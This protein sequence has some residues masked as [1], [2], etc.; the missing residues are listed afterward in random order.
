MTDDHPNRESNRPPRDDIQ[1]E[2]VEDPPSEGETVEDRLDAEETIQRVVAA[3]DA[4]VAR[5]DTELFFSG[6]AAGFAITLTFLLH[7]VGAAA[8]SGPAATVLGS[9][10]YPLGFLYII[11]GRYQLYTENTLPPVTLVLERIA[12]VPT[13]LRVWGVVLVANVVG[14]A[15]GAFVLANSG[16]MSTDVAAAALTF[17]R[18]GLE[19]AAIDLFLKALFAGWLV[20]GLVWMLHSVRDSVSR[21]LLVYVVF[22]AIPAAELYHVVVSTVDALYL[23]FV[24]DAGLVAVTLG[25][26]LPVLVGNTVGGVV[27]VALVNY[28]QTSERLPGKDEAQPRL[29]L[30]EWAFGSGAD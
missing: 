2:E 9:L 28:A 16:V 10:L 24:G 21:I 15:A 3:A 20:A 12:S 17:G 27:F 13:L 26:F 4:E 7:A 14:A 11:V 8:V 30:R 5:D 18:G 6:L 22:L 25:F 1:T 19:T 23:V 29:S